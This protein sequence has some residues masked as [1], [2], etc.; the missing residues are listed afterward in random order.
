MST[1]V[2]RA[3]SPILA[4][5]LG[6]C[7]ALAAIGARATEPLPN[8]GGE[9]EYLTNLAEVDRPPGAEVTIQ[10]RAAF[11]AVQKGDWWMAAALL[12][13]LLVRSARWLAQ[14]KLPDDAT[15]KGRVRRWTLSG[16]GGVT[17]TL[18]GAALSGVVVALEAHVPFGFLWVST[19]LKVGL[20][21]MG[22]FAALSHTVGAKAKES[23]EER[24]EITGALKAGAVAAPPAP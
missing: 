3:I 22:G 21:S 18:A 20:A 13:S 24:R 19:V 16:E 15:W 1:Q 17:L 4:L 2:R 10:A 6:A 11:D 12:L 9:P 7:V 14:A 5:L 23:R 8:Y